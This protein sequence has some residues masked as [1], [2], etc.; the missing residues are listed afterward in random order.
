MLLILGLTFDHP[1]IIA[2]TTAL[3]DLRPS[4]EWW[5]H[6]WFSHLLPGLRLNAPGAKNM[7]D[8]MTLFRG[9]KLKRA[10]GSDR[11]SAAAL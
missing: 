6:A 7:T 8:C 3:R 1:V 5:L 4:R 11:A 10:Y 2:R 9:R